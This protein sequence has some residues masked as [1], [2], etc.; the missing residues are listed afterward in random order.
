MNR[1]F[2]LYNPERPPAR[3]SSPTQVF[4]LL[5]AFSTALGLLFAGLALMPGD[6]GPGGRVPVR[7]W[8]TLDGRPWPAPGVL[9]FIPDDARGGPLARPGH[10]RFEP[11][12]RFAVRVVRTR[13][14]LYPGRY[15]VVVDCRSPVAVDPSR[16][17]P[18]P[19]PARYRNA[20]TTPLAIE[21][22][23]ATDVSPYR[24]DVPAR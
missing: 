8:I 10:A 23:P 20:D 7:G 22:H 5:A 4:L 15:R 2:L 3:P 21:V 6:P 9:Y 14:G 19:V 11:D 16:R 1:V 18:G 24:L 17:S 13:E 12:G